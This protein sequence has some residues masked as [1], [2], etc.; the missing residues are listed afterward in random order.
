MVRSHLEEDSAPWKHAALSGWVLDPDRK[1]MSK[2][3]GNVVTP[4]GLLEEYGSDAV[5]Y[6]SVNGRPGTDTAFDDGQMKVGRRLAIKLLN[7]SRFTLGF[8]EGPLTID[9]TSITSPLDLSL[10]SR[11]ADLVEEATKA[12]DDFDY[13]R[14]I[15]RTESFFWSFTDDYV[16][17][18]KVR[19]YEGDSEGAES[20]RNTLR[21][22]LSVLL[23]LF[24]PFLP[25]VTEEVWSWWKSGSVHRQQW[26]LS[27][28]LRSI[29]QET[30][31]EIFV[32]A[33]DALAE[34]RKSKTLAKRSL[35]TPVVSCSLTDTSER[36]D[37]LREALEDVVL[38]AKASEIMLCEGSELSVEVELEA[39][40]DPD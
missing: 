25:F 11:L 23:R 27:S 20:A 37:L 40:E 34:I 10:L 5:R 3:K 12:F 14:A 28:D 8:G 39:V 30:E 24:A 9:P 1:K 32:V 16:E 15:E 2:S 33:S 6:W 31:S 38:G 17:L 18:V 35:A 7:A 13:A 22:T 19:A 36:L 21:L 26:P 29:A 4:M